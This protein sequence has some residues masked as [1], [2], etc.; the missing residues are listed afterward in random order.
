VVG[1]AANDPARDARDRLMRL[2]PEWPHAQI[3][4]ASHPGAH[5]KSYRYLRIAADI[6]I[7]TLYRASVTFFLSVN[8]PP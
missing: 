6:S 5:D 1:D 7:D 4:R 2:G 3:N 8:R